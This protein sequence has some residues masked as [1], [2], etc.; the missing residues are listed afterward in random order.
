MNDC[1]LMFDKV[2]S[3]QA[4]E[5]HL[6]F[7]RRPLRKREGSDYHVRNKDCIFTLHLTFSQC[8]A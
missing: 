8:Q 5:A 2:W 3:L 7:A 6:G 1:H 4:L